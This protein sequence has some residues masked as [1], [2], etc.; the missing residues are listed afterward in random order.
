MGQVHPEERGLRFNTRRSEQDTESLPPL[1]MEVLNAAAVF[2]RAEWNFNN[3]QPSKIAPLET[4]WHVLRRLRYGAT[5]LRANNDECIIARAGV[6]FCRRRIL[7]FWGH[8]AA[9]Q[10]RLRINVKMP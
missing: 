5:G 6:F 8:H 7:H 2:E 9:I 3:A 4:R 1:L 10:P